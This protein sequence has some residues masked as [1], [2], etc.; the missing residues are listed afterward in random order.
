MSRFWYCFSRGLLWRKTRHSLRA[1]TRRSVPELLQHGQEQAVALLAL[2][3]KALRPALVGEEPQHGQRPRHRTRLGPRAALSEQAPDGHDLRDDAAV[4]DA[5]RI[6]S[7][8]QLKEGR[9]HQRR[10]AFVRLLEEPRDERVQGR[11]HAADV[12]GVRS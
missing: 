7:A 1:S 3:S 5:P 8:A 11:E 2:H 6:A 9:A 10:Q 12:V 4:D